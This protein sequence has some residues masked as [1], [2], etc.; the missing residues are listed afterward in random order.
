MNMKRLTTSTITAA[1]ILTLSLAAMPL[2]AEQQQ[3]PAET[4]PAKGRIRLA[5]VSLG[6]DA[7]AGQANAAELAAGYD[8]AVKANLPSLPTRIGPFEVTC[9]ML[10]LGQRG[11]KPA[12]YDALILMPEWTLMLAALDDYADEL[13]GYVRR[14]GGLVAFQP[15]PLC[16]YP[17]GA[18]PPKAL[19]QRGIDSEYCTPAALPLTATFYNRYLKY[20]TVANVASKKHAITFDLTAEQM[21]YPTDQLFD[22]DRHYKVLAR[23]NSSGSPSLAAGTC[24]KGRIVLIA[25]NVH[26]I[27][28]AGRRAPTTV[29]ARS[30]LWACGRPDAIIRGILAESVQSR[31]TAQPVGADQQPGR[32]PTSQ[33]ALDDPGDGDPEAGGVRNALADTLRRARKG[34]VIRLQTGVYE[35]GSLV[36]PDGVSLVGA[37]AANTVLKV[38]CPSPATAAVQLEGKSALVDLTVLGAPDSAGHMIRV[39]GASAAPTISRCIL[40]PGDNDSCALAAM[41][42][43]AP[44]VS[45]CVIVSPVGE[46][47]IRARMGAAPVIEYSTIFSRG[48][49]ISLSKNARGVIRRCIVTG[50]CP[51]VLVTGESS[52]AMTDCV[53]FC[54]GGSKT[55]AFPISR[56]RSVK[57]PDGGNDTVSV[58]PVSEITCRRDILVLDP[59]FKKAAGLSGLLAPA[60]NGKAAAYGAYADN[61]PWPAPAANAPKIKPPDLTAPTT[62][63]SQP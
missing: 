26:G 57:A 31:R 38:R 22:L 5:I 28:S 27:A 39:A 6:A 55:Y 3:P 21:P 42:K 45:H 46:C 40:L 4:A 61:S 20:E 59:N 8:R 41:Q 36:L 62:R 11:S 58:D 44:T 53:L 23:G 18:K 17:D 15:N 48:T 9:E 29:V 63:T 7:W 14:G 19:A 35:V 2:K 30:L 25:D 43:A 54:R 10:P 32:D 1:A 37:G 24:G 12:D 50:Q 51:G 16:V 49:G 34:D 47:G 13:A 60:D 33:G 56:H 52:P